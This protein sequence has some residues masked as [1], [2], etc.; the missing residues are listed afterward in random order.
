MATIRQ[1]VQSVV[2]DSSTT[3]EVVGLCYFDAQT[4][5]LRE[6]NSMGDMFFTIHPKTHSLKKFYIVVAPGEI[7]DYVKLSANKAQGD[8]AEDY[9][10]S[11][12]IIINNTEPS[13]G[14]FDVLPDFNSFKVLTP[15]QG[16]FLSVWVLV[17]S[18]ADNNQL[19]GTEIELS[20]E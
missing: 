9:S 18:T 1:S 16:E 2:I 4:E 5:T 10:Y 17:K 11:V 7:L 15:A 8:Y 19:M 3:N 12:K 6:F 13:M 14:S 20:Y